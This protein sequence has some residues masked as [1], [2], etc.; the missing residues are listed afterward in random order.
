[1]A[2]VTLVETPAQTKANAANRNMKLET[3]F[4]TTQEDCMNDRYRSVAA[5]SRRSRLSAMKSPSAARTPNKM[6]MRTPYTSAALKDFIDVVHI[7]FVVH[8]H[9]IDL[10]PGVRLEWKNLCSDHH[11]GAPA[12]AA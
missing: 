5:A 2:N 9:T 10:A 3:S 12:T 8:D 4:D 7:P 6:L 11:L 1:M